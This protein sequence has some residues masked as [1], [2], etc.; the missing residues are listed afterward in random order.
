LKAGLRPEIPVLEM[1]CNINDPAFAER[2]AQ[3][4]LETMRQE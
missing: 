2:C 4:L 3:C 1:D